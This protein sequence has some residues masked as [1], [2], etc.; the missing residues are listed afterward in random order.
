MLL[1][2]GCTGGSGNGPKANGFGL[3]SAFN[4]GNS[5]LSIEFS[6]GQPPKKI[7]DG[8]LQPFTIRAMVKNKGEYDIPKGS[9]HV[10]VSGVNPVDFGINDASQDLGDLRGV[11]KQGSNVIDGTIQPVIFSNLKY[12]PELPSGSLEQKISLDICY[13]YKTKALVSMCVSGN[14][15]QSVDDTLKVCEI[16]SDRPYANSG[17]PVIIENVK[18]TP[19]GSNSVMIQFDIVHKKDSSSSG[20]IYKLGSLDTNCKVR[21]KS[22]TSTDSKIDENYIKF[23]VDTGINGIDCG[24]GGNQGEVLL[25][26]DKTT[27]MCTQPTAGEEDYERPISITLDYDYFDRTDTTV[28]IEHISQ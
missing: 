9:T 26:E 24:T 5:A 11:K 23:T 28:E 16:E 18:Q 2:A 3:D 27:V 7:R 20:R 12:R 8:G 22:V 10:V 15:L 13:P 19:G 14:T 1:F 21:G 17:G 4:G 6:E 25:S